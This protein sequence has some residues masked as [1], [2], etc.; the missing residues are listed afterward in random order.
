MCF[1]GWLYYTHIFIKII[2]I[3]NKQLIIWSIYTCE[4]VIIKGMFSNNIE[5]RAICICCGWYGK[6]YAFVVK[7]YHTVNIK[8]IK[9]SRDNKV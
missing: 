3:I 1:C 9:K 4:P 7:I 6:S 8:Y 2:I 5:K